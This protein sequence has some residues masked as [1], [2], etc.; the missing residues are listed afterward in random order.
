MNTDNTDTN[1]KNCFVICVHLCSSVANSFFFR[2]RAG[3]PA[4][5]LFGGTLR[6]TV[7]PAPTMAFSPTVTRAS[8]VAPDPMDA[9][10]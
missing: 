10:R 9:P 6:V 4:T 8:M 1:T 3:F 5:T 7:L 2:I